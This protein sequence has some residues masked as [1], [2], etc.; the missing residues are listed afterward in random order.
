M[1]SFT[2]MNKWLTVRR[3]GTGRRDLARAA[4]VGLVATASFMGCGGPTAEPLAAAATPAEVTAP[5]AP[6]AAAGKTRGNR[7]AAP[8]LGGSRRDRQRMRSQGINTQ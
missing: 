4:L 5:A 2:E 7:Q 8:P 6:K 1:E 3:P